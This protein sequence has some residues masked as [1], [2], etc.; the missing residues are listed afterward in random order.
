MTNLLKRSQLFL[1]GALLCVASA[2]LDAAATSGGASAHQLINIETNEKPLDIVL[3]WISRRA[4]VN[5]VCNEADQPLVTIRLVNV[6]WQEGIEQIAARYD[7]VLEKKS[8]RIWELSRPPRVRMKFQDAQLTVV[9]QSLANQANVNIV[10]SDDVDSGRR[11]TMTLNGVPWKEALNVIVRATGYTFIEH[12]Y[13]I[14]RVV[15][16]ENVQKDLQTRIYALNYT[17]GAEVVNSIAVAL[18]EDGKVVHDVRTNTLIITDTPDHLESTMSL[19]TSLDQRTRE[20]QIDVKFVEYNTTDAERIGF[21]NLGINADIGNVGVLD[22]QFF[23]FAATNPGLATSVT[24]ANAGPS[25]TAH[26]LTNLTFE[27]LQTLNSTEVLQAPSILTLNNSEARIKVGNIIRFAAQE[28]T[29]VDGVTVTSL[30]EAS[31]SPVEDGIEITVTPHITTDGFISIELKAND[32]I[33]T[34]QE[35]TVAAE[36]IVLPQTGLKEV[37]TKI[38]VGDGNTAILGGILSNQTNEDHRQI[39]VLGS[40]P[41]IGWLF[42]ARDDSVTQRNT[43]MFI[44]ATIVKMDEMDELE[45]SKLR[46]KER[47]SGL[48][49]TPEEGEDV[50][51]VGE[52]SN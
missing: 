43:T 39:P 35:F 44:T 17:D 21:T 25:G 14:I 36:S 47:L 27:A 37:D 13:N 2:Q 5:I 46:L 50:Q 38:M 22:A 19:L 12:N 3:Q 32:K 9:L 40:L 16:K 23:P 18:S 24:R 10:I 6:T 20:V 31:T 42:R 7:M 1:I 51:S 48:K 11:L 4:G 33:V 30:S 45:F 15:S 8:E 41:G 49:L 29:A 34:L 26:N 52:L 28:T